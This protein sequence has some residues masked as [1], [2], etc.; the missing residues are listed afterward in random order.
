[1]SKKINKYFHAVP[2]TGEESDWQK[3]I[4]SLPEPDLE[5]DG[6]RF[7]RRSVKKT[8]ETNRKNKNNETQNVARVGGTGRRDETLVG[9]FEKGIDIREMPPKLV[10]NNLYGGYGRHEIFDELKYKF[11]VYDE[12]EYCLECRNELQK[13]DDEVL[14]DAA[15]SDNGNAKSKPATKS[16]YVSILIKRIQKH[17]W[18]RDQMKSWFDSIDHCLTNENV[19][20]YI[21]SAIKAEKAL[22]CV[23]WF[24]SHSVEQLV[25]KNCPEVTLLNT[26]RANTGNSQRFIRSLPAMMRSYIE[27]KGK[28]QEY[29][30]WNSQAESHLEIDES[31]AAMVKLMNDSVDLILEFAACHTYFKTTTCKATK[32]VTQ[33]IGVDAKVG[34]VVD[35]DL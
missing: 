18:N 26:T 31:A 3:I 23:E 13:N 32:L 9:S 20:E 2:S 19:R 15:L 11:W 6:L 17:K 7:V 10:D 29:C 34:E 24:A 35:Y 33:K 1:M 5:I 16:D 28:T 4:E 12:Y 21:S 22:G 8:S 27:S 25:A 14:E 30:L